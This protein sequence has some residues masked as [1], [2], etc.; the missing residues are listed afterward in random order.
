VNLCT[1]KISYISLQVKM[2]FT[3]VLE[4]P[5]GS[6]LTAASKCFRKR[7]SCFQLRK[8]AQGREMRMLSE[9]GGGSSIVC[10]S[11]QWSS[12]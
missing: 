9:I 4:N 1:W 2:S 7:M 11:Y 12:T 5:K 6:K 8:G 3:V 10:C